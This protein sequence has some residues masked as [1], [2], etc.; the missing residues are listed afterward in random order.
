MNNKNTKLLHSK[1]SNNL[2]DYVYSN[3]EIDINLDIL[4]LE[5]GVS[6]SHLHKI[7]KEQTS[8][9]IYQFI[10]SIRLQKASNM[11]IT[12]KNSTITYISNLCGYSSQTSFI[13]AFKDRFEQT[14]KQW[15]NGG[16]KEYSNRILSESLTKTLSY[17]DFSY[18]VPNIVKVKSRKAY[19]VRQ[20]GYINNSIRTTWQKMIAWA[21]TNNL[22]Q[23][24]QIG[25]YHD[26]PLITPLNNCHYVACIVPD[27]KAILKEPQ[28]LPSFDIHNS[29]CMTFDF[30]GTHEDILKLIRW[31]NHYW[32]PSSGFEITTIPSYTIFEKN[33]FLNEK[34]NFKGT[35]YLPIES[36]L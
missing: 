5:Y 23:F 9:P 33:H 16:Y 34:E 1:L 27:E 29:I 36:V 18:I 8:M 15:R 24:E 10:K 13:R 26:N 32:L 12:N 7:F 35:Y 25:I 21:F 28:N 20:K 6:K 3:I 19:Y 2:M 22:E 11:L 31:V 17:K 30:E 4:A 14:P